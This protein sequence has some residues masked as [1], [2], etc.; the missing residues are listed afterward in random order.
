MI[1][2]Q[3]PEEVPGRVPERTLREFAGL[4][5]LILGG[6]CAWS[7]YRHG[8]TPNPSGWVAGVL[9]LLI[10]VPGLIRPGTIRPVYLGA[11]AATAPI[12]HVVGLALLGVVYYGVLTPL[13]I[14][15]RLAGRDGLGRRPRPADSYWVDHLPVADVRHYLRQYQRQVADEPPAPAAAATRP[16]AAPAGSRRPAGPQPLVDPLSDEPTPVLPGARHGSA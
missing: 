15:F 6:L 8:G 3:Y 12:G 16:S 13:A 14:A 4:C 7:G 2:P 9:A 11:M 5:L 10:G 1:G